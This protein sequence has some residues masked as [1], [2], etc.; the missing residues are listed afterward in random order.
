MA[1]DHERYI[2]LKDDFKETKKDVK[3][4]SKSITLIEKSI[5]TSEAIQKSILVILTANK[6]TLVT[7]TKEVEANDIK[8]TERMDLIDNEIKVIKELPY[9]NYIRVK[10]IFYT[11]MISGA[12]VIFTLLWEKVL[13]GLF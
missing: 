10:W 1:I 7:L 8:Y 9:K 13:R 12:G 6:E 3:D 11:T 2:D 5:I 4:L